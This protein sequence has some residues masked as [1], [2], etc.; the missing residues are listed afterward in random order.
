MGK[1]KVVHL[2]A[3]LDRGGVEVWL[4]DIFENINKSEIET[5]FVST[6]RG[7][8]YFDEVL[9]ASGANIFKLPLNNSISFLWKLYFFLRRNKF[10]VVHSHL[11]N[12]SGLVMFIAWLAKVPIRISH[13]HSDKSLANSGAGTIRKLYLNLTKRLMD[14]FSTHKIACSLL[15]GESLFGKDDFIIIENGINL[16]KFGP[17]D[18]NI[19]REYMENFGI[20]ENDVV[21][22]HVGRFSVPK[23]HV[24]LVDIIQRFK[25]KCDNFRVILVGSGELKSE[26]Q[27]KV[28]E[29]GLSN[30]FIFAGGR[31]DVPQLMINLFDVFLFPSLYEGM[32]I[33]LIET[34]AAGLQSLI[35]SSI[36]MDV[37][38]IHELFRVLSL[39]ESPEKWAEEIRNILQH[40]ILEKD[41]FR[42]IIASSSLNIDVSAKKLSD[43]YKEQ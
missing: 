36:P 7:A 30:H 2:V 11:L 18:P 32:P 15:A 20:S 14:G 22:G 4:K 5:S 39:D 27:R 6:K 31:D 13:S 19:R 9:E 1:I 34:Q 26:V 42:N 24:F 8:G 38:K 40:Q 10:N 28:E 12:F 17:S 25:E 3:K 37:V 41:E 35:S 43:I 23:N 21:I 33:S 16:D 29:V